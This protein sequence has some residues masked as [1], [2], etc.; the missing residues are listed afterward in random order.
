MEHILKLGVIGSGLIVESHLDAL[1]NFD[2]VFSCIGTRK[3]SKRCLEVANKYGFRKVCPDWKNVLEED[4][5]AVLIA[6]NVETNTE[7]LEVAI[8][9]G[10]PILIEKPVSLSVGRLRL[11]NNH[12]NKSM[13]KVG[14][15]RRLY[16]SVLELKSKIRSYKSLYF[17]INISEL[18]GSKNLNNEMIKG[19]IFSNSVHLIDLANFLFGNLKINDVKV[20]TNSESVYDILLHCSILSSKTIHGTIHFTFG[21]P[22]RTSVEIYTPRERFLLSPIEDYKHFNQMNIVEPTLVSKTRQYVPISNLSDW[23]ISP[24]DLDFKPG[25]LKQSLLFSKFCNNE[26]IQEHQFMADLNDAEYAINFC[27]DIAKS[28]DE[29]CRA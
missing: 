1:S 18:S 27:T 8:N 13:V 11:L 3:G 6:A 29:L 10:I 5:E 25:F 22:V 26:L 15:N 21:S 14:Y 23:F 19:T 24:N 2:F 7:A 28:I 20:L 4:I 12:M 9:L 16:S 17:N